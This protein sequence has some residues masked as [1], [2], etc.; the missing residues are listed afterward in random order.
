MYIFSYGIWS[1]GYANG[2]SG[3]VKEHHKLPIPS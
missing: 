1:R 3:A 2:G